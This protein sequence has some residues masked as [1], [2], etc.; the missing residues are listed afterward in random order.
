MR[1]TI[2]SLLVVTALVHATLTAACVA[3]PEQ[4]ATLWIT[5]HESA[6]YP[7]ALLHIAGGPNGELVLQGA[8]FRHA[9]GTRASDSVA[10]PQATAWPLQ[11]TLISAAGDTL[12]STTT[13]IDLASARLS[14]VSLLARS[15]QDGLFLCE[16]ILAQAPIVVAGAV[17]DTLYVLS[18]GPMPFGAMFPVC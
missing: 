4:A 2:H 17:A 14:T 10:L 11:A 18:W 5:F 12:A 8:A 9:A 1:P 7:A 15:N 6:R 13:T 3:R 16:P